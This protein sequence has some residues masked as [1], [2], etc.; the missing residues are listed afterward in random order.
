VR[1]VLPLL[2]G[3]LRTS[4]WVAGL[5]YAQN[6]LNAL[7]TLPASEVPDVLVVAPASFTDELV[8]PERAQDVPWLSRLAVP[9]E[10]LE[11]P[12]GEGLDSFL[13]G[14]VAD[15]A[16]PLLV[17][18]PARFARQA[19]GWIP[20]FQHRAHPEL[21]DEAERLLRDR[22]FAF[23]AE[24]CRRI[25]CSSEAVRG[26]LER[27]L[28]QAAAK[29]CL[30][31]FTSILPASAT[32]ADPRPVLDRLHI[33]ERYLYLPN[34]FWVHKN[35]RT[36]FE[37]WRRLHAR[38]LRIPLVCTGW[39]D[40]FRFPGYYAELTDF[41]ASHGLQDT[42]R[43]LG[44]VSRADQIQLYRGAAAVLQPSTFEGWSTSIEDARTLGKPM[45]VSDIPVH[46]EQCG[47]AGR[48]FVPTDA[49]ALAELVQ[50]AWSLLPAGHD[51][52]S[53]RAAAAGALDRARTFGR[54]LIRLFSEVHAETAQAP[55]TGAESL[56]S[57][58][59]L[60]NRRRTHAEGEVSSLLERIHTSERELPTRLNLQ[61]A[62]R[63][64]EADRAA[65]LTVIQEQQ[66]ALAER[67]AATARLEKAL[68]DSEADRAARGEVIA[69]LEAER[70]RLEAERSAPAA[71]P[72][73]RVARWLRKLGQG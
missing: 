13:A 45:L 2:Q 60:L 63:E 31:R 37:A 15:V 49:E 4:R 20:D 24:H 10:L 14:H 11:A 62:L 29:A 3:E 33:P 9:D 70:Q 6:V 64:S 7:A 28:P 44:F 8:V 25:A 21:F 52:G 16:F 48:Y 71:L 67:L 56:L 65:R 32:A 5:Y 36:A 42:V 34:Q 18:P 69:R 40:D 57:L 12:G 22:M 59:M 19:I 26:D 54:A 1:I 43:L 50:S 30:L 41:L 68:A 53:E 46:R 27:H 72:E 39:P 38:G 73:K 17:M 35:H 51:P 23:L 47:E 55:P 61:N 66:A 58:A